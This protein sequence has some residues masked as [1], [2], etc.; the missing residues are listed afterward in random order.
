MEGN[1]LRMPLAVRAW[2]GLFVVVAAGCSSAGSA[3]GGG[4]G[5]T[6]TG[7]SAATGGTSSPGTGGTDDAGVRPDTGGGVGGG[8]GGTTGAG[9]SGGTTGSGGT[10]GSSGSAGSGGAP[11]SGIPDSGPT[12]TVSAAV[13]YPF[14]LTDGTNQIF[15]TC[16]AHLLGTQ[17]ATGWNDITTD[18]A[19]FDVTSTSG[20]AE[21]VT[22]HVDLPGYNT[23]QDLTITVPAN[24]SVSK[25]VT[26]N[27]PVSALDSLYGL[28]AEYP[29]QIHAS[30][31]RA[32]TGAKVV[33]DTTNLT[34]ATGQTSFNS[35]KRGGSWLTLYKYQAVF[36]MPKD[37]DVE[38]LLATIAAGSR[39][40]SFG[41][42]G[43]GMHGA[44]PMQPI[45]TAISA[46]AKYAEPAYFE[47]GE[48]VTV[49]MPSVTCTACTSGIDFYVMRDSDYTTWATNV[50]GTP[51]VYV[52][53]TDSKS[54][55]QYTFTAPSAG[56]YWMVWL[57]NCSN[58]VSR[59]VTYDRTGTKADTVLDALGATYNLL[60]ARGITYVSVASSFFDA[61]ASQMLRWPK[62]ALS[63]NAANCVDGS[64]LFASFM[65]AL[66]LEPV[67]VYVRGHAY[68]GVRQSAGS[69][70]VWPVETTMLGTDTFWNAFLKGF[71]EYQ[72]DTHLA[73][74]DIK[75]AR[76]A[77]VLPIPK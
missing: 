21:S 48:Q 74:L 59:T 43:Y 56:W 62:T 66:K 45:T 13:R 14:L 12:G 20:V 2:A 25:C 26:P 40:G 57:N 68:M 29:G 23:A 7:G 19:C 76:T 11:D 38:G 34:Y 65:E 50:C 42:M 4:D 15:P 17:L 9:G 35:T 30:A 18:L 33:D 39:W 70:L 31:T 61:T 67:V 36:S 54:G 69:T 77:G 72:T 16:F 22:L 49:R 1:M 6:E 46:S 8:S 75:A 51:M 60:K 44:T 3:T 32:A 27:L 58:F 64:M 28:A 24:G 52:D 37:P 47:A 73:D 55:A 71:N 5:V 41:A 10:G 53:G 63:D